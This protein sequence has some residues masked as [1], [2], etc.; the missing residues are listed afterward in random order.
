MPVPTLP[1]NVAYIAMPPKVDKMSCKD[2]NFDLG[3][4]VDRDDEE[5]GSSA[6]SF[7]HPSVPV[8]KIASQTKGS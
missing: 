8:K 2:S 7:A 5:K 3:F 6:V 4:D 1:N